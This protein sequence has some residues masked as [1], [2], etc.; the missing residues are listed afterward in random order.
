[1]KTFRYEITDSTN[2]RAREYAKEHFADEPVLFVADAQ[3][4]GR[5]RRGRSFDSQKGGGLYLSLLF[6]PTG[7]ECDAARITVRAAVALARALE[8]VAGLSV[9]IKWVNDITVG[10]KKLAGILTEGEIC[11][12]GGFRYAVCG[13]GVNLYSREFPPELADIVTTVEDCV[14]IKADKDKLLEVLTEEFFSESGFSEIIGEYR[15]RSSVIGHRV[16]VRRISGEVFSAKAIAI[17][18]SA[19][20]LVETEDGRREELISAEVSVRAK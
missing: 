4:A 3:S 9:C 12:N 10:G 19:A 16:E 14:G 2:T 7:Q 18:D 6:K 20:L 5:G 17:T 13:I 1:M 8:K 11:E 15:K